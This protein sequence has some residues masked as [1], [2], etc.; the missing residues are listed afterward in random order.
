MLDSVAL[1][2]KGKPTVVVAHH[3]FEDVARA[4]AKVLG[5]PD[6]PLAVM[7]RPAPDWDDDRMREELELVYQESVRGLTLA[8]TAAGKGDK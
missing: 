4:G 6:V 1:E 7:P 3:T 5:L 2:R 8:G